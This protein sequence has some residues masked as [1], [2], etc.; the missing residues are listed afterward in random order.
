MMS[1]GGLVKAWLPGNVEFINIRGNGHLG[2][3]KNERRDL[4][5]QVKRPPKGRD[6]KRKASFDI[7]VR[8]YTQVQ[9]PHL[10]LLRAKTSTNTPQ[11]IRETILMRPVHASTSVHTK[12]LSPV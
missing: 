6:I 2:L 1:G 9:S 5:K 3:E 8:R 10:T 7:G 12:Y 11:A 4:R